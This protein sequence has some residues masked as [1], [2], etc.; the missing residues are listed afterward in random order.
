MHDM[1]CKSLVFLFELEDG[2]L[3]MVFLN[4]NNMR[5][6]IVILFLFIGISAYADKIY[7]FDD[8]IY[9]VNDGM[10]SIFPAY[11]IRN[12]DDGFF[13]VGEIHN[14]SNFSKLRKFGV[15][16][17]SIVFFVSDLPYKAIMSY[18]HIYIMGYYFKSTP[19]GYK[20]FLLLGIGNSI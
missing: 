6:L 2:L 3:P 7:N 14:V 1:F 5:K 16:E 8:P 19:S 12:V 13:G 4:L 10:S 20:R 9:N 17:G 18:L 15:K 11:K